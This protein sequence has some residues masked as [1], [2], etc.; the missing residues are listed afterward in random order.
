MVLIAALRGTTTLAWSHSFAS[1]VEVICLNCRAIKTTEA[2]LQFGVIAVA[3]VALYYS[4]KA[5]ARYVNKKKHL[6][7]SYGSLC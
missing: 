2:L 5:E 3:H 4:S 7:L 1:N 6:K